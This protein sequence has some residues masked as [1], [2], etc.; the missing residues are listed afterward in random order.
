M[1]LFVTD[2][3]LQYVVSIPEVERVTWIWLL[4]F[5]YFVPEFAT[6]FRSARKSIFKLWKMEEIHFWDVVSL[7]VTEMCP[8]IGSA[9]LVYVVLPEL[10]AVKG[11]MLTNAVC[12]VPGIISM[13]SR[14]PASVEDNFKMILDIISI[15]AQASSFVVWPLV[16]DNPKLYMIPLSVILI[17]LGWWENFVSEDS[18]LLLIQYLGKKKMEFKTKTYFLYCFI[19]PLKC[20]FFFCTTLV[21]FQ[22]SEGRIDFLFDEF[23]RSFEDHDI[24]V[25]EILPILPPLYDNA[26]ASGRYPIITTSVWTGVWVWLINIAATYICYAFGKFSCKVMIQGVSYAFPVN[27]AV[28]VLLSGL[29]AMSGMYLRDECSFVNTIPS[30]LFFVPPPLDFLQDFITHNQAWIWL[31]WLLSQAWLSIHIWT[32]NCKKL[33]STEKLFVRPMYDAFLID[34]SLALNR[35]RHKVPEKTQ[36]DDEVRI[37]GTF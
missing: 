3:N 31:V 21:I 4:M 33:D 16:E 1:I 23:S 19:A 37:K 2:R 25:T 30:Y 24:N 7:F 6:W 26:I 14:N 35:R 11:A 15:V 12:F 5:A 17:S 27:L 13:F 29:I 28:P 36:I 32:P 10:D 22:V 20:L 9:I 34:Q 8:A 18:P